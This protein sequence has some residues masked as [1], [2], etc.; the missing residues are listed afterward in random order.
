MNASFVNIKVDR[1]ERPD[2]DAIYMSAVQAMTG[3]GGWPLNVFLTPDG[4]PFFGGTYW[5]PRDQ[6]GM[7]GFPRVLQAVADAWSSN[8]DGVLTTA[9]QLREYLESATESVPEAGPLSASLAN[10]AAMSLREAFDDIHGG[11]GGAPKFPQASVLEFL[12]RHAH[13][14]PESDAW[15]WVERTLD[16]MAGGGIY[17]QI[18]GGFARYAVD[19]R[20]L[21]PHF[22][23]MLYDNAQLLSLYTHAWLLTRNPRHAEVVSQTVGW[24]L[25]EMR[26]P[27]GG[28]MA[29]LDADS[30]G[31]EGKFYVWSID[32]IDALLTAEQADLVKLHYG[33]TPGGNFEGRSILHVA[34]PLEEL[35][36]AQDRTAADVQAMLDMAREQLLTVRDERVR[37]GVDNKVI[38]SWNALMLK[39]L[40]EAGLAFDRQDWIDAATATA[41]LLL[42]SGWHDGRLARIVTDGEAAGS[43]TLEDYAFLADALLVLHGATGEPRWLLGAQALVEAIRSRFRHASGIGFYDT[44]SDHE[45]LVVRPRDLQDGAVPCGN[46]VAL[47]AMWTLA[48]LKHDDGM[49]R[50]VQASLATLASPMREHPAAFGR[51]LAV[52]ERTLAP[53]RQV[54][55][56]GVPTSTSARM[57]RHAIAGLAD[58][59]LTLAHVVD[60]ADAHTWPTLA[61][62]PFPNDAEA[63]AFVCQDQACL[64]PVT[65]ARAL[66]SLLNPAPTQSG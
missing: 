29:A 4:V 10:A 22:E 17:D 52:H 42:D 58:P 55:I 66:I 19:T 7:P 25:R 36:A 1:E 65:T 57:L 39:A 53:E 12:R 49:R 14:V 63:A 45:T 33:M 56:A 38:V 59:F 51:F 37:P 23:K 16:G 6:G 21:V 54:V 34:R 20:W 50:E 32:E 24:A 60:D 48:H 30:E 44:A 64:P 13:R 62:R 2:L 41:E 40:A 18:G 15:A 35:A 3:Q 26:S 8:R 9:G 31:E 5:P 46:S 28:F 11:F 27:G 61:D 43:G 47:D